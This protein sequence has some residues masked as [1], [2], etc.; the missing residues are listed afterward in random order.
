MD[1][2]AIS[3]GDTKNSTKTLK[4]SELGPARL[5]ENKRE[6]SAFL[7]RHHRNL[8]MINIFQLIVFYKHWSKMISVA[9]KKNHNINKK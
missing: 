8:F 9:S 6:K 5:F 7:N 2:G 3:N 1:G 4:S